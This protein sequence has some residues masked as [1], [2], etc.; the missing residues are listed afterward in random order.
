MKIEPIEKQ[1]G[2]ELYHLDF[3]DTFFDEGDLCVICQK[4]PLFQTI[5]MDSS[6]Y[7]HNT[8]VVKLEN[9]MMFFLPKDKLITKADYRA[10][11]YT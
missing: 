11:E 3:G 9:G 1:T 10:V 6:D 4:E 5:G 7:R 8:L 2:I